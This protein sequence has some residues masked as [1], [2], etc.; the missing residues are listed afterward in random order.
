MHIPQPNLNWDQANS[1]VKRVYYLMGGYTIDNVVPGK[2]AI[3]PGFLV[4]SDG[5]VTQYNI[6]ALA[7]YMQRFY[8]GLNYHSGDALSLLA[9]LYLTKS[10]L[11]SFSYDITTSQAAPFGG[12]TEFLISYCFKL[13]FGTRTPNVHRSTRFL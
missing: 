12:K 2:L 3:T 9:G 10:L 7:I 11:A 1:L 6:N 4:Q 5:A 13:D 8:G